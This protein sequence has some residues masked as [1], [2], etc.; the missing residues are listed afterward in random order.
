MLARFVLLHGIL[1]IGGHH[2]F[3]LKVLSRL[4][5]YR[6]IRVDKLGRRG[7]SEGVVDRLEPFPVEGG[8]PLEHLLIIVYCIFERSEYLQ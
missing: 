6:L 4:K 3:Q 5:E 2:I 7:V 1:H 8:S